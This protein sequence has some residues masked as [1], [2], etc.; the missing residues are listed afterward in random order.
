MSD[1]V[2]TAI[3][4]RYLRLNTHAFVVHTSHKV[5]VAVGIQERTQMLN[6]LE[7]TRSKIMITVR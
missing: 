5:A 6:A 2:K 1:S 4:V 7:T 3:P